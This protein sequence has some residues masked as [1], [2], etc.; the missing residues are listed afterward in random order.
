MAL[1][2]QPVQGLAHVPSIVAGRSQDTGRSPWMG[3]KDGKAGEPK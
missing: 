3:E 1:I 2:T